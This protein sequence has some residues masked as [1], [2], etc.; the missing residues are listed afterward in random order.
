[1]QT[2][3]PGPAGWSSNSSDQEHICVVQACGRTIRGVGEG[4]WGAQGC[5]VFAGG[6][7]EA[8]DSDRTIW[9]HT[10]IV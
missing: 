8:L 5:Q 3:L 10:G 1:M 7:L 9:T 6:R 2:A 4:V